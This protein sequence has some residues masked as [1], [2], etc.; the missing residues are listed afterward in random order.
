MP[1]VRPVPQDQ[2][3]AAI[4]QLR[5][6]ER[7]ATDAATADDMAQG[8]EL[9]HIVEAQQVVGVVAV[10]VIGDRATVKAA[11]SGGHNFAAELQAIEGALRR[12]GVRVMG[13]WTRR[14]G[15]VRKLMAQGYEIAQAEIVKGL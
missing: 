13:M 14:P 10:E 7:H 8:C 15:L 6:V 12:R 2:R 5:P 11:A 3:A 4:E 1:S 9:W